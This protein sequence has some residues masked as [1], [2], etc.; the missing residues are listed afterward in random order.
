MD[1][2]VGKTGVRDAGGTSSSA[3]SANVSSIASQTSDA[4]R[5]ESRHPT[6]QLPPIRV[7]IGPNEGDLR[8]V[9]GLDSSSSV[10][11]LRRRVAAE[12][13][14][15]KGSVPASC[16]AV[17]RG[18]NVDGDLCRAGDQLTLCNELVRAPG[19]PLTF[20]CEKQCDELDLK[21]G[22]Y[23]LLDADS[24]RAFSRQPL[25]RGIAERSRLRSLLVPIG[26]G[27]DGITRVYELPP[28]LLRAGACSDW[29]RRLED[30]HKRDCGTD[31]EWS[32]LESFLC[33]FSSALLNQEAA[34]YERWMCS[35]EAVSVGH[36]ALRRA[37]D[38]VPE[39]TTVTLGFL[40]SVVWGGWVMSVGWQTLDAVWE[41]DLP[42][43]AASD[44]SM[45]KTASD[46]WRK[47][48]AARSWV[49]S[50]A[51]LEW[52]CGAP[53][54]RGSEVERALDWL[55]ERTTVR[56]AYNQVEWS[57]IGMECMYIDGGYEF[58]LAVLRYGHLLPGTGAQRAV[59]LASWLVRKLDV[60]ARI[61]L[62]CEA[63]LRLCDEEAISDALQLCA[64][65]FT[66]LIEWTQDG[67][68]PPVW[69]PRGR[70]HPWVWRW[71]ESRWRRARSDTEARLAL[72]KDAVTALIRA[73]H[74]NSR[75]ALEVL[76]L[77]RGSRHPEDYLGIL[78]L[79][80]PRTT[81][82]QI[83]DYA[84]QLT[85]GLRRHF[86]FAGGAGA[87]VVDDRRTDGSRGTRLANME[88]V[89]GRVGDGGRVGSR[90]DGDGRVG[91]TSMMGA[92]AAAFC[93][94][95]RDSGQ[96]S[97]SDSEP[98][99][100]DVSV[101][102][103]Q[104]RSL[105]SCCSEDLSVERNTTVDRRSSEEPRSISVADPPLRSGHTPPVECVSG[106][107][108][109]DDGSVRAPATAGGGETRGG[110]SNDA[111][112]ADASEEK[113]KEEEK[114]IFHVRVYDYGGEEVITQFTKHGR[115]WDLMKKFRN[116]TSSDGRSNPWHTITVWHGCSADGTVS[117][118]EAH[119]YEKV[120]VDGQPRTFTINPRFIPQPPVW[121]WP[122]VERVLK[123]QCDNT[124]FKAALK[125]V[126]DS[127]PGRLFKGRPFAEWKRR[128]EVVYAGE[129][130]TWSSVNW[131]EAEQS[132]ETPRWSSRCRTSRKQGA[133]DQGEV[134]FEKLASSANGVKDYPTAVRLAV[135]EIPEEP[136]IPT[137]DMA[138]GRH[139]IRA[140]DVPRRIC[141][142]SAARKAVRDVDPELADGDDP[143]TAALK[144]SMLAKFESAAWRMRDLE[145]VL[146]CA[147]KADSKEQRAADWCLRQVVLKEHYYKCSQSWLGDWIRWPE[148]GP[149]ENLALSMVSYP[150]LV[151]DEWKSRGRTAIAFAVRHVRQRAR[152][153][154][155]FNAALREC[156]EEAISEALWQCRVATGPAGT[157]LFRLD[158]DSAIALIGARRFNASHVALLLRLVKGADHSE[159]Y[160]RVLAAL[161]GCLRVSPAVIECGMEVLDGVGDSLRGRAAPCGG[162]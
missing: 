43:L 17:F 22:H 142:G 72:D 45:A 71:T 3:R 12:A 89:N 2:S 55:L 95:Q 111:A 30:Y 145:R 87:E 63:A 49:L 100:S 130:S 106:H 88:V 16:I 144:K 108:D 32:E 128:I 137:V 59:M 147:L 127:I 112:T 51:G 52:V 96:K 9:S 77:V 67:A 150:H 80:A 29:K 133:W 122:E 114:K 99:H 75:H 157:T 160:I 121:D 125:L 8:T 155:V 42:R 18:C 82:T 131:A 64:K 10:D 98:D 33:S 118:R 101:A 14:S 44:P 90:V 153:P 103:S 37:L 135:E 15:E 31:E 139:G 4:A 102:S 23:D 143:E 141:V 152:W 104:P 161:P 146:G 7:Y 56:E 117:G 28:V 70:A 58:P 158:A 40:D 68:I 74:F 91:D 109:S 120:V 27:L 62:L 35:S 105:V 54:V 53:I 65:D 110:G 148:Y 138:L 93:I 20:T 6:S 5:G 162:V 34:V 78:S 73:H 136:K 48:A 61:P 79:V 159:D 92:S 60:R 19:Q 107:H 57:E 47:F 25:N 151:P 76:S 134:F 39:R 154:R 83:A 156:D 124:A 115:V 50:R 69:P 1:E 26:V 132:L 24:R 113:E 149:C 38:E 140:A 36:A 119:A 86:R 94:R 84:Q 123:A 13:W 81:S 116:K 66:E 85:S 46:L 21:W 129:A 41:L 97:D 11:D 126:K